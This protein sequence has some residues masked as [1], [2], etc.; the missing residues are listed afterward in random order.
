MNKAEFDDRRH[1]AAIERLRELLNSIIEK[2]QGK[3]TQ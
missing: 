3:R 2:C 1:Y